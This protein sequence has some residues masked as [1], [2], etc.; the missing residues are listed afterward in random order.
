MP[1]IA[2][3]KYPC[4]GLLGKNNLTIAPV[5]YLFQADIR[6]PFNA[7]SPVNIRATLKIWL[8][9]FVVP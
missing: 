1:N 3:G 6:G 8:V 5:F 7:Y 4:M 9:V 2:Q